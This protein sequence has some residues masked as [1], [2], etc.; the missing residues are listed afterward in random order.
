LRRF[1]AAP[2]RCDSHRGP[3]RIPAC[4]TPSSPS[5]LV[6]RRETCPLGWDGCFRDKGFQN[7]R[8]SRQNLTAKSLDMKLYRGFHVGH[9]VV[10]GVALAHYHALEAKRICDVAIRV[11]LHDNL[12]LPLHALIE[13][14]ITD[15]L[16][17]PSACHAR[18]RARPASQAGSQTP[19]PWTIRFHST[20]GFWKLTRRHT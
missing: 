3:P 20:F 8:V 15:S 5:P 18:F 11:L 12:E 2:G 9:S 13:Q 14:S 6:H 1:S 17:W 19:N 4:V 16:C 7:R 10:V